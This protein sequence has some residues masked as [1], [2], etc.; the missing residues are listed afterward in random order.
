[1][2]GLMFGTVCR[3]ELQAGALEWFPMVAIMESNQTYQARYDKYSI[4]IGICESRLA[5]WSAMLDI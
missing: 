4:E 5:V 3:T 2:P 1:M